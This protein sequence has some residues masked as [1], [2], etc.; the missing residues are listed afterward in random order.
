[1][2]RDGAE[3]AAGRIWVARTGPSLFSADGSGRG[4]A[5]AHFQRVRP[6]GTQAWEPVARWDAR[7]QKYVAVPADFGPPGDRLFLV[8]YGSGLRGNADMAAVRLR[9]GAAT[10]APLYAGA[11]SEFPGLDQVV[12]ELPRALAGSGGMFLILRVAGKS[13]NVL[14]VV[15]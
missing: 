6:D 9:A 11:H 15:F 12:A 8:L 2:L 3:V 5:A 14:H 10:L 7:E 1:V 13:A 4:L